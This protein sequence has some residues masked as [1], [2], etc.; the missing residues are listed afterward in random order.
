M[1]YIFSLFSSK[2]QF[3]I[4]TLP[5]DIRNHHFTYAQLF[6]DTAAE[7]LKIYFATRFSTTTDSSFKYYTLYKGT[8]IHTYIC[9]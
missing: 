8:H 1:Y 5:Q 2:Y 3:Y 4:F 7:R 6:L 9:T